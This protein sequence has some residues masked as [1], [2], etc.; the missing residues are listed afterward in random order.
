MGNAIDRNSYHD[1]LQEV[2]AI[3]D[4]Y[5]KSGSVR[6]NSE[7]ISD[8]KVI[9]KVKRS[10]DKFREEFKDK[11]ITIVR[12]GISNLDHNLTAYQFSKEHLVDMF[13][14]LDSMTKIED[15]AQM[16]MVVEKKRPIAKI[17]KLSFP[18][19]NHYGTK[20]KKGN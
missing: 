12:S 11:I 18:G 1:S 10:I 9:E 20:R 4:F 7:N 5:I 17:K 14:T 6:S 3:C 16:T 8:D 13:V 2:N 19:S 15:G